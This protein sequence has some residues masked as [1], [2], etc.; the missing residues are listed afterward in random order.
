MGL[1]R[2]Y[3]TIENIWF[4]VPEKIRFLLVGG[5]NTLTAYLLFVFFIEI[6]NLHYVYAL[7]CMFIINVNISI[8][9]M[10]YYVFRSHSNLLKEY[11][12]GWNVYIFLLGLNYAGLY[13]LIDVLKIREIIAQAIYLV[14]STIVT[15]LIHK[16]ITFS[17]NKQL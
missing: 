16:Y 1:I 17:K 8:L 10:R 3:K 15:Y 4:I 5:F 13:L 14:F 2:L 9:T 7:S 6:V 12:K 11:F